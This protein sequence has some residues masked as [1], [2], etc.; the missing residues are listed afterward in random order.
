MTLVQ[1]TMGTDKGKLMRSDFVRF[2]RQNGES[3]DF[4]ALIAAHENQ[5]K[6][7][8]RSG[9]NPDPWSQWLLLLAIRHCR[10]F[11]DDQRPKATWRS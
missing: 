10:N 8:T 11:P 4:P 3:R 6:E 1:S 5:V 9:V 2:F 7:A